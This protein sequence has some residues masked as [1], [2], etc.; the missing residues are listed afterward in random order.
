[1]AAFVLYVLLVSS[2]RIV[3]IVVLATANVLLWMLLSYRNRH[4]HHLWRVTSI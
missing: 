4:F 2:P 1:V 3:R